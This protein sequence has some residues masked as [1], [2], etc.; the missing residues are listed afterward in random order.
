[1]IPPHGRIVANGGDAAVSRVLGRGCW[2]E[3][4][5][6]GLAEVPG[7]GPDWTVAVDGTV[8]LG[9]AP[10]GTLTLDA[11]G[12]PQSVERAR[13]AR[14]GAARRRSGRSTALP[15]S[16]S[17]RG[18][19]RRRMETRGTVRGVTVYD[20][21]AHHPTAIAV[22]ARSAAPQGRHR[23]HRRGA[24]AALEHDEA[25]RDEGGAAGQPRAGRP[26]VLLR[27][28]PGLGRRRRARAARRQGDGAQPT[29]RRWWTRSRAKRSPA[30][31]CS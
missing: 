5:R 15:R 21:F 11:A 8:L 1:M 2:S 29:C 31:T 20:D 23:A 19:K 12:P 7:T 24:R 27:G 9:G 4:E 16:R 14:R 18:V 10:Q 17:F 26:R 6:F 3:V 28:E 13:G 30:I 25:R 22:H